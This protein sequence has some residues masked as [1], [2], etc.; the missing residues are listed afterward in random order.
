MMT[1]NL[2]DTFIP[3]SSIKDEVYG[4]KG[5]EKRNTFDA[6]VRAEI[7]YPILKSLR[8]SSGVSQSQLSSIIGID[9]P[10]ISKIESA[11]YDIQLSTFLKFLNGLDLKLIICSAEERFEI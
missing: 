8:K 7:I 6:K 9:T 4:V 11:K 3:F 10:D 5:T 1:N 2:N